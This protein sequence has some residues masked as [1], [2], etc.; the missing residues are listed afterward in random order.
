V[1]WSVNLMILVG[2]QI[3]LTEDNTMKSKLITITVKQGD[4]EV[5]RRYTENYFCDN[6]TSYIG[7]NIVDMVDILN[8]YHD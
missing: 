4:N 5:I 3:V 8:E 6:D 2:L 7:S 1:K